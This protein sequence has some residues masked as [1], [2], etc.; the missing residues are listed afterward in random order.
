MLI[1]ETIGRIRR[2]HMVKG[3]SIREIARDLRV[4]RNTVRKVLRSGETSF[5]YQRQVQPRPKIGRWKA[6]LDGLLAKNAEATGRE[7]LTLIRLFEELRGL[8]YDGGYDAVRRYARAWGRAH[9]G[10]TSEA[11]VPLS[12]APGEALSVRLEPR[13]RPDEWCDGDGKG[14]SRPPVPQPHDVCSRV[15]A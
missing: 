2:E 11:Y 5:S 1:V 14:C 8:G 3:K 7:R 9:A 13:N 4:S 6:E 10:Q 15:S 12:F